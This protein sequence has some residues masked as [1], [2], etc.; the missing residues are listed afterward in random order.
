MKKIFGILLMTSF[1]AV[2]STA[3]AQDDDDGKVKKEVKKGAKKVG[4]K[5]AEVASKGK[6]KATDSKH[7]D[8]VGPNGET[9]YIDNH[10]KYYWVDKKG[11]RHYLTDAQLKP[12]VND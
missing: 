3:V 7:K 6:A 9:V 10:S 11:R 5:T 12:K 8:K 1:L 4:N 2:A